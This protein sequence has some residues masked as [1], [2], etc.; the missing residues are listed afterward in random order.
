MR[1]A[2]PTCSASRERRDPVNRSPPGRR[3]GSPRRSPYARW[4]IA[5]GA[6]SRR[7]SLVTITSTAHRK[8]GDQYEHLARAAARWPTPA[9]ALDRPTEGRWRRRSIPSDAREGGEP[10][11]SPPRRRVSR[12]NAAGVAVVSASPSKNRTK[13]RPPPTMPTKARPIHAGPGGGGRLSTC[14]VRP[15]RRHGDE[16]ATGE[17][18]CAS[19]QPSGAAPRRAG[20]RPPPGSSPSCTQPARTTE[21]TP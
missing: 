4:W 3:S 8:V 7:R 6:K 14:H 13:A 21:W 10:P 12:M 20:G 18:G 17:P 16:A 2:Q 11:V 1:R 15:R 9:R 5:A 19:H